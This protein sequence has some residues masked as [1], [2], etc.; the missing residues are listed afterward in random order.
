MF[1]DEGKVVRFQTIYPL[2]NGTTHFWFLLLS[3]LSTSI[4]QIETCIKECL[5]EQII[6]IYKNKKKLKVFVIVQ[7]KIP[8][9][10]NN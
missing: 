4:S 5:L 2:N 6:K 1:V 8:N 10:K 3:I 9:I 7:F